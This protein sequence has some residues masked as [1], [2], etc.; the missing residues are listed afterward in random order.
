MQKRLLEK[1]DLIH[2]TSESEYEDI[3]RL[4]LKQPVIII[5][6]GIDIPDIGQKNTTNNER[7]ILFISRIHP[8]H[9]TEDI[10]QIKPNE[11]CWEHHF[12]FKKPDGEYVET[13]ISFQKSEGE[14]FLATWQ[15]LPS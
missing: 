6:N 1:A 4:G 13:R 14:R 8:D 7:V 3:R 10:I 11:D 15:F 9:N 2:V 5:P 12:Q